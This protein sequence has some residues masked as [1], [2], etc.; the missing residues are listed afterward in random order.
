MRTHRRTVKLMLAILFLA[1]L[2]PGA[3]LAKP[4]VGKAAPH[5]NLVD[6]VTDALVS[7]EDMAYPGSTDRPGTVRKPVLL[8][9][10]STD[11][12]PCK[13]SLPRLIA[14]YRKLPAGSVHFFIVALPESENGR[15]KLEVYFKKNPVPFPV[16]VDKYGKASKDYSSGGEKVKFPALFLVDREGKLRL[17]MV[18]EKGKDEFE[19]LHRKLLSLAQ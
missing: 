9:F 6:L 16:L 5:F 3:A 11:C 1:L 17:S 4:E 12:K 18:G 10:F 19:K 7:L 13:K 2:E 15:K 8:D 14:L